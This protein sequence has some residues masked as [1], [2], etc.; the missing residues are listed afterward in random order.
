MLLLFDPLAG[1]E[2]QRAMLCHQPGIGPQESPFNE[3]HFPRRPCLASGPQ[4][5][6]PQSRGESFSRKQPNTL[7][8]TDIE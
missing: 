6:A 3:K 5:S 4:P 7:N 1:L 8:I 2:F